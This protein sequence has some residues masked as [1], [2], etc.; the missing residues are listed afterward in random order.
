LNIDDYISVGLVNFLMNMLSRRL[1]VSLTSLPRLVSP[2][3]SSAKAKLVAERK[4][5]LG[6]QSLFKDRV[7]EILMSDKSVCSFYPQFS[8]GFISN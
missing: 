8:C 5:F 6:K 1:L 4:N 2:L 7:K 3:S